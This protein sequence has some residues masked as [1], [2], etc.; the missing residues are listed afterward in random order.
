MVYKVYNHST[1]TGWLLGAI[2]FSRDI[3][4]EKD[5]TGAM[6]VRAI[7]NQI[8]SGTEKGKIIFHKSKFY[9][10]G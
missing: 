3:L 8:K 4:G 5:F 6:A 2:L 9:C 7:I 1:T 10:I